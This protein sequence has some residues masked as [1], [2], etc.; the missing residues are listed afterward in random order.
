MNEINEIKETES[1]DEKS[2][3]T[4]EKEEK[5]PDNLSKKV[6]IN[7]WILLLT[8]FEILEFY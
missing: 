1:I 7:K 8:L 4:N 5:K 2:L 3:I 6:F